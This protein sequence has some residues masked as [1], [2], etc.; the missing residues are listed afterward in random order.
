MCI[1]LK[2]SSKS[3]TET[4]LSHSVTSD[5]FA[6]PWSVVPQTPLSMGFPRQE[7]W[8]GLPFS[9]SRESF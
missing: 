6:I 7:Y 1:I 8:N 2:S 3:I 4:V 9:F 5:S